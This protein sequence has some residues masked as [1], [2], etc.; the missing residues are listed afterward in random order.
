MLPSTQDVI[1]LIFDIKR[2]PMIF[3]IFFLI[4]LGQQRRES[5]NEKVALTFVMVCKTDHGKVIAI[6]HQCDVDT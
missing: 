4:L 2:I 3:S 5:R 6:R 1:E